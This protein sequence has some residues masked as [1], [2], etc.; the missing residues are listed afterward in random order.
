MRVIQIGVGVFGAHWLRILSEYPGVEVV[1]IVDVDSEILTEAAAGSGISSSYCFRELGPALNAVAADALICVS[2]PDYHREHVLAAMSAGLDV[3]CEKPVAIDIE[4]AVAMAHACKE[5]GRILAVS[6]NYRFRPVTWTMRKLLAAGEVGEIGQI[7]LDF[8][9]GWYFK[10]T[11]F[12]RKMAH[13]LLSDMGIHHFDLLRF[14]SGMEA[15]S[16]RGES[17]NP[18]WSKN[19]GDTSVSVN[20]NL[21]NG[22]RFVYSASWCAQGDFTDWNGNWLVE[23]DRG[24]LHYRDGELTLINTNSRYQVTDSRKVR[25]VGPPLSDQAYVLADFM[26]AREEKCQPQTSIYDNLGSLAMVS[27]ARDAADSGEKA[28]VLSHDEL[29]A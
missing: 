12:R 15:V 5:N 8:Y 28:R 14:I 23:G 19:S 26:A 2:P 22:T 16:V 24:S 18:P 25:Q 10:T 7:S 17:W 27:A 3:I 4:D 6:Q 1:A 9:K 29:M 13:P 11:D 20:F 21:A